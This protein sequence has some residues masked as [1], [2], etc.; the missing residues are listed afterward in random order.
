MHQY[1]FFVG[2][3]PIRA[4]G[5][6]VALAFILGVGVT[7]YLAKAEKKE[8]YIE[9]ILDLSPLLLLGGLAGARFW[10][11]FFFDWQYYR[12]F[13]EEIIAVWHG[14]L[15][16]QGGIVGALVVGIIYLRMKHISFWV[17][18][19]L[20]APGLILAQSIGRNANLLNGDAFGG[21]TGGNFGI[22][23]PEGTIARQTFGEQ[24]LWPAEVWEG[25]IDVVI[26]AILLLLKLRQWIPGYMFL[27]YVIF[28][29][30]SRLFLE[31]LRGDSSRFLFGWTAAQWSS[32]VAIC[33]ALAIMLILFQKNK[34]RPAADHPDG[35]EQ[36]SPVND[37]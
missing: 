21:P 17:F 30:L 9:H 15:S 26:F 3:F 19:D 36:S 33:I 32:A 13:P 14:G 31:Y 10:Q 35:L 34:L 4:Y 8:K 37:E 2:N 12:Q 24:P 25:Q 18:A 22:L 1:W 6:M 5:T 7:V 23:Y 11:V 27:F 16:I 28:Y 29:N 20:C